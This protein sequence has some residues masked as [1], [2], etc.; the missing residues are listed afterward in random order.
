METINVELKLDHKIDIDVRLDDVIDG[1]NSFEMKRRWN[2]V[3]LILNEIELNKSELTPEQE[4][5]IKRYLSDKLLI[6]K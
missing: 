4:G 1:I 2:Y 6:F 5:I 3:A